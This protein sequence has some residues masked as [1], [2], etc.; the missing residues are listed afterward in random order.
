ML[1]LRNKALH[2]RKPEGFTKNELS[3]GPEISQL[4][5]FVKLSSMIFEIADC[6][7][8]GLLEAE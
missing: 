7:L 3:V 5:H 2:K 8:P 6:R 1:L 4:L